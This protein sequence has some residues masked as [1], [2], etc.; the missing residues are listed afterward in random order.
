M[1]VLVTGGT[2]QLG[3]DIVRIFHAKYEVTACSSKELDVTDL[4]QTRRIVK[5][6][7]PDVIIH[8]GAYTAVDQAESEEEQA[9]RVNAYGSRN[10]AMAA[11]E[12]QAKLC[13]I[14]TDYVFNG[15]ASKPYKEYDNTKPIGVYGKSKRAGELFVQQWVKRYFIVRTSWVFGKGGHNFVKTM[16][17]LAQDRSELQVVNDQV[18]SPTYTKDLAEF[19]L[20]L[21]AT[22]QYG[23]YHA[24]NTGQ[25]SWYEFAKAIFEEQA[26]DIKVQPC[27]TEEFPR[28]AP[29]PKYSVL[30]HLSIRAQG[31]PDLRHWREGL[32]DFLREM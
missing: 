8:A 12:V 16:L 1:K 31:L 4:A 14:S 6:Q 15:E 11:A 20:E 25:C 32:R 2:G 30:D 9:Y 29:R 18:G 27:T 3:Q 19:L 26:I 24:T 21:T 13:Y 22:E 7:Q 5:E 23:I 10:I 28:P 17:K